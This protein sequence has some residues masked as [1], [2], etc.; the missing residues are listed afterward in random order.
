MNPLLLSAL[1]GAGKDLIER[2]FPDKVA[3]AKE[4]AEAEQKLMEMAQSE[5]MAAAAQET[6]LAIAQIAVNE[7]E[8]QNP[9]LFVSGWRPAIGW[10]CCIGLVYSFLVQPVLIAFHYPAPVL[11]S[12][13]LMTLL[14]GMLG[15]GTLRSI[16]KVKGRA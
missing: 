8:A 2:L 7:H 9:N 1:I 15:L 13:V 4:R 5:R 6:Q 11:D 14:G 16:E 12:G 10:T 3:Q